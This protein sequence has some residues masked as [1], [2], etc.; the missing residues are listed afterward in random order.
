MLEQV[1]GAARGHVGMTR[2]DVADVRGVAARWRRLPPALRAFYL[3]HL[4]ED[5]ARAA[6]WLVLTGRRVHGP[7]YGAVKRLWIESTGSS[8]AL[9]LCPSR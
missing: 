4:D 7:L 2:R 3:A 9:D 8:P 6:L 1:A 5:E